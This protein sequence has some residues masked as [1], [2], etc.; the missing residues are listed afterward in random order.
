MNNLYVKLAKTNMKNNKPLYLPYIL[1]G[2]MTV[3][4]F[5][6]ILFLNGNKG[7]DKMPRAG[8]L[9]IIFALGVGVM[10]IF[11]YIFIF[12][13]NSFIIKRRKREIGV[14]NILGMEKRHIA[15]VLGLETLFVALLAIGG[16]LAFGIVFSKLIL[17]LL[18]RILQYKESIMF[19]VNG[20]GIE[21]TLVAFGVLYFLTL[22]HNLMQIGLANPIELLRGSNVGEKE[23][24][25]KAFSTIFGVACI[26]V[27]YYIAVTAQN[28]LKVLGMFFIAVVLVM[29]GT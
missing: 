16:G 8:S 29:L 12:Y 17:M 9:R 13:T 14:Y 24:K 2:I 25:T 26:A 11:S 23:P 20:S 27:A 28:P 10:G 4:M 7:L 22:V 1:S 21:L 19:S 18:Y 15:K 3:A 6:L 5:Y